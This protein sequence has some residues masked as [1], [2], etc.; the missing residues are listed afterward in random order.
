MNPEHFLGLAARLANSNG[1]A[2]RR[3]AV[4]RAYYGAFHRARELVKTCDVVLPK[5]ADIHVKISAC[6]QNSRDPELLAAGRKLDSFRV[7]R[8]NA[9]YQLDDRR[10]LNS[11]FVDAQIAIANDICAS[12]I[13]AAQRMSQIRPILRRYA[14]DVMRLGL[15]SND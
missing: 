2:E 5:T 6:L 4:S 15:R 7:E 1:E 10:F 3:S 14:G 13:S 12:I 9:D 11:K 8:N